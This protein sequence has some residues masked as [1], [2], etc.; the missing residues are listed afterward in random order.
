[1]INNF[2]LSN[3][4]F[5]LK[6]RKELLDRVAII[7][8]LA[9]L[10]GMFLFA[11]KDS[12]K[13]ETIQYT[14]NNDQI[15]DYEKDIDH[16][17]LLSKWDD[18][19]FQRGEKIYLS[20][21]FNCHGNPSDEGSIPIARKFWQEKF[22]AGNDPY[23][24]YQTLTKGYATMPPQLNLVPQQKYDVI[25]FIREAYLKEDNAAEYV[26][27]D[28]NYLNSLPKGN[29]VGPEA[30]KF[31]PWKT[32]DYG[33]FLTHTYELVPAN[34]P[35]RE[36][37]GGK[38][39]L[40]D[41]NLSNANFAYKGIAIR[42]N[43]G[44]GGIAAGNSWMIF[45]HD[46]MRVAGGW[47]GEGFIDWQGILLN[48]RHNIAPRTIGD[49]HFS[50]PVAPGWANPETGNF[51]DPRFTAREGR[52]FG[53]LPKKW[54]QFKGLY[55]THSELIINYTIGKAEILERLG[56]ESSNKETL[57][58]RTLYIKSKDQ[59][60]KLRVAP[61]ANGVKLFGKGAELIVENEFYMLKV[62]KQQETQLTLYISKT[63]EI[64]ENSIGLKIYQPQLT[65]FTKA[66]PIQEIPEI[67]T[68]INSKNIDGP[69][70]ID[71]LT[72]PYENRWK[73][74]IRLTGIDFINED[75]AAICSVDGEVWLVSGISQR[76]G[77]LTWKRI[78]TGLFQPL[79]IKIIDK[80]IVVS[81]RDQIVI[82][83]DLNNDERIDFYEN[84]NSDHQ[85]T[86]H[87]HEFAMGLQTD[88]MGNLYYAKSGRHAREALVPQH[89]TLLKVSKDGRETTIIANGFRAANGVCLNP[90][91]SFVVT[92]QEGHWNPMNRINWVDK[93]GFYGN[94]FGYNPPKDSTDQGMIQ[95]MLWVDKKMDRSPSELIWVDSE[96]WGP[97]NKSLLNLSYGYGTMYIVPHEK[98]KDQMQGGIFKLPVPAFPTG[99]MR[100]RFH[101][102]DGQLYACGM[103]AWATQQT[104]RPGGFYRVRYT[105]KPTIAPIKI[106][107]KTKGISI[108]FS[109]ELDP[110]SAENTSNYTVST[111]SLKRTRN[112]GSTHYD[113]KTLSVTKTQLS[114]DG[115]TVM[116]TLPNIEKVWQMEIKFELKLKNGA[117]E[118]GVIQNTIHNLSSEPSFN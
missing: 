92:D 10:M 18:E 50:N 32:M 114:E 12:T 53:P 5:D 28:T 103:S 31:E 65:T 107:V 81:C 57:F 110:T 11:C 46:L 43:K 96:Q 99:V 68:Q 77:T 79:G 80:K 27:I 108:E 47:T 70:D 104:T 112:Y 21:C 24:I 88:K 8:L 76:M 4:H 105:G 91:G 97:F 74:R 87:F 84:F 36:I 93:K 55:N 82:L 102:E 71:V 78:A 45:D 61:T 116:L 40:A 49:L 51:D 22:V 23:A 85:V 54:A 109:N 67:E 64:L 75:Q 7:K 33:N 111:W 100:G 16:A 48:G 6:F 73:S 52:Q 101:P 15:A 63:H 41:E 118:K 42:L 13:T 66:G 98:I 115:K 106:N 29:S 69:F 38:A 117:I 89:G 86:D 3:A 94:M 60:L 39:P 17:Q 2:K 19:A 59:A 44:S 113:E 9:I 30:K 34:A 90:D 72:P 56:T 58:S 83:H 1:M 26:D 35:E 14:L 95:P 25:H 37:S 62:E 20:T